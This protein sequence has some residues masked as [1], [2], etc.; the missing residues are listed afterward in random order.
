[1]GNATGTAVR[2]V[3]RV[4]GRTFLIA[5]TTA[6]AVAGL[7]GVMYLLINTDWKFSRSFAFHPSVASPLDRGPLVKGSIG[8]S[9]VTYSTVQIESY[10]QL[11]GP[12]V[13]MA[14]SEGLYFLL[15]IAGCIAVILICRRLWKDRPFSRLAH[16]SLLSLG[17]L[18]IITSIA[19]PWLSND[20]DFM[21]AHQLG[22]ATSGTDV[23]NPDTG[24]WI[25]AYRGFSVQDVNHS[26]FGLGAV[27]ALTSLAFRRGDRLQDE[28]DGL[29]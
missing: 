27:L 20:A 14:V 24:E 21:A 10:E 23:A 2:R 3:G 17:A 19:S 22:F 11:L 8:E 29:V 12:R 16:W 28:N 7:L 18:A 9:S 4:G 15:F 25:S 13:A 5:T 6:A 26:L 1:M